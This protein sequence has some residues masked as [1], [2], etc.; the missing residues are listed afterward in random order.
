MTEL[1]KLILDYISQLIVM[2]VAMAVLFIAFLIVL[3]ILSIFSPKTRQDVKDDW[4]R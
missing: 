3:F 4:N 2:G 1:S